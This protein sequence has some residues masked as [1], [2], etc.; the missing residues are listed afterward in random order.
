MVWVRG[1]LLSL[2]C[3]ILISFPIIIKRK[4]NI[5]K[6]SSENSTNFYLK[7]RKRCCLT[8]SDFKFSPFQKGSIHWLLQIQ[9]T[10]KW[11]STCQISCLA[12]R[13]HQWNDEN[14]KLIFKEAGEAEWTYSNSSHTR[15]A[16][17]ISEVLGT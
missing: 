3:F 12:P 13:S 10:S 4:P 7:K 16:C 9:T 8:K 14:L 2:H 5:R 1:L 17:Q 6:Q 15:H 11:V